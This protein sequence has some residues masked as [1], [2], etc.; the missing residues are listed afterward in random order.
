MFCTPKQNEW[1]FV[2][3]CLAATMVNNLFDNPAIFNNVEKIS[4]NDIMRYN[5]HGG[6]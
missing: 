1:A 4:H 3:I 6:N 2:Y 5:R